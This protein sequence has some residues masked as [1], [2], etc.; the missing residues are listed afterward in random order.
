MEQDLWNLTTNQITNCTLVLEND[1]SIKSSVNADFLS[2]NEVRM[3]TKYVPE[4]RKT[5]KDDLF[6]G[7]SV[8]L[9]WSFAN[10]CDKTK[11]E[12]GNSYL[13]FYEARTIQWGDVMRKNFNI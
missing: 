8:L 9:E 2:K 6:I 11:K 3:L 10:K 1:L 7:K 13:V 12:I 5:F 4:I